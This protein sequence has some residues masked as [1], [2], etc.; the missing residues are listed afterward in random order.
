MVT[1]TSGCS[2]FF[3]I[4][5]L[6]DLDIYIRITSNFNTLIFSHFVYLIQG[7][8]I[9]VTGY[10]M[11]L[12]QCQTDNQFGK[13]HTGRI[14]SNC[15]VQCRCS[16]DRALSPTSLPSHTAHQAKAF[17]GLKNKDCLGC[18]T[19]ARM[20]NKMNCCLSI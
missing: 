11:I 20:Q 13:R 2:M 15:A 3:G 4:K 10:Y 5:H 6:E 18:L 14:R 19:K 9:S 17:I 16:Q 7:P 1:A 8:I 12:N